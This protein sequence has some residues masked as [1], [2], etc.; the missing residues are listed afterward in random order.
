MNN[1]NEMVVIEEVWSI[2]KRTNTGQT[3]T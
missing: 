1:V 3:K 2:G